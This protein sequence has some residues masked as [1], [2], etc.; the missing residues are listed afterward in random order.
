VNDEIGSKIIRWAQRFLVDE[1][2][3][4]YDKTKEKLSLYKER[5]YKKYYLHPVMQST[6]SRLRFK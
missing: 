3:T 6:L 5:G 2:S 4:E 1:A